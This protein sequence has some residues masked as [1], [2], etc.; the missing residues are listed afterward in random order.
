[1]KRVLMVCVVL[2]LGVLFSAY[3]K[4]DDLLTMQLDEKAGAIEIEAAFTSLLYDNIMDMLYEKGDY[5]ENGVILATAVL[6][7]DAGL[8]DYDYLGVDFSEIK[9][10]YLAERFEKKNSG[11]FLIVGDEDS[12]LIV[13][14][15]DDDL[16][17]IRKLEPKTKSEVRAEL[18]NE[19][20]RYTSLSSTKFMIGLKTLMETASEYFG[21]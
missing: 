10:V 2:C 14:Y 9:Y 1:M 13:T 12:T 15:V 18:E 6:F 5:N 11:L 4:N 21:K 16:M 7:S 3:T 8:Y 19:A 17:F 20:H